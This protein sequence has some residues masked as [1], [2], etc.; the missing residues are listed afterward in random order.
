MEAVVPWKDL[1]DL[2]EPL[3]AIALEPEVRFRWI[4]LDVFVEIQVFP[5]PA[6]QFRGHQSAVGTPTHPRR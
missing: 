3:N 4:L 5:T 1:I 2:I 6:V